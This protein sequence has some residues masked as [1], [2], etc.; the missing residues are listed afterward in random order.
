MPPEKTVLASG[1]RVVSESMAGVE[2]VSFGLYFPTGSR[3]ETTG[4]N[5]V[6]HFIEHLVFKG[7]PSRSADEINREIDLLGGASNAYT[8]K[9]TI[10]LYA[11]VLAENLG[12][13]LSLFG[14]LATDALPSGVEAE[15]ERERRVILSEIRAV[16]DSPEELV[17]QLSDRVFFGN[18]PL[19]MPIAGSAPA[20]GRLGLDDIRAHY[21]RHLVANGMVVAAAG[22][23]DHEEL[24]GL[25]NAHLA[26]VPGG[27][28]RAS[29]APPAPRP[30]SQL[31]QRDLEQV[32]VT[33][34]APGVSGRDR[35]WAAAELLSVVVG[36]GY[37]SR[38]FREVRDRRGLVYS[39]FSS[40]TSYTDTGR[41]DISFSVSAENLAETLDVIGRELADV[42]DGGILASELDS[43]REHLRGSILLGHE[44]TGARMSY[45]A[46]QLLFGEEN[47]ELERDLEVLE[48]VTLGE[49]H[50]LGEALLALPL[51]L[52]AVGPVP[53]GW[54]PAAGWALPR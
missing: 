15:V 46:E 13:L 20:V 19:A 27:E 30:A 8:S 5:G 14:D 52:A 44:S 48:R 16:E 49:V 9:E 26:R 29:M 23:L 43:A 1:A 32:H 21:K 42:R 54:L 31:I 39:I 24:V 12:R 51:S 25:V 50:E 10:C 2:S 35:R 17:G 3:H 28:A 18:H 7:T 4:E 11:R 41:F 45:L 37:S 33:L 22:K 34:S 38:L 53:S 6:S 47:L 36:D 40:L